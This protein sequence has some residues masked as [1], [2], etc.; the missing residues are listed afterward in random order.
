MRKYKHIALHLQQGGGKSVIIG[1][2]ALES[3]KNGCK[4]LIISHRREINSQNAGILSN[5]GIDHQTIN[6]KTT[7]IEDKKCYVAMAQTLKSRVTDS[8]EYADLIRSVDLVLIDEGH[9]QW[10][11]FTFDYFSPKTWVIGFSGT[12]NRGGKQKQLGLLYD[13]IVTEITGEELVG[14]GYIVPAKCYGFQAPKIEGV[15]WDY[16][17]GDWNQKQ[18]SKLFTKR[19]R[20]AGIVENYNR[21]CPNTKAIVFTTSSEHCRDLCAEFKAHGI[22]SDYILA[23]METGVLEEN[24]KSRKEKLERFENGDTTVLVNIDI[25][26]TGYNNPRIETVILDFDTEMYP[27]YSQ[28]A[29]RGCRPYPG[30]GFYY[31]L[32]FGNNITKFGT[33]EETRNQNLWHNESKGG[34]IAQTKECPQCKRLIHIC[35]R[36]CPFCGYTFLTDNEIYQVELTEIVK[37]GEG[38]L[39]SFVAEKKLQGWKNDWILRDV[40]IKNKDNMKKAFMEAIEVLRTKHNDPISPSYWYFFKKHKLKK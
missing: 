5:L 12:W 18:L 21:I 40:C 26:G 10:A 3:V 32:D 24:P 19:E 27:N 4:V 28:K 11:D 16:N 9:L 8:P 33:P 37:R 35:Y 22:K 30:K 39:N 17:T 38:D 14:L 7:A 1:F 23:N 20:Y 13:C 2:M 34:G 25:L 6:P 31:L 15:A 29:A 36:N